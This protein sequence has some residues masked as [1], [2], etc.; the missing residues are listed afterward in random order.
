MIDITFVQSEWRYHVWAVPLSNVMSIL[1]G[2]SNGQAR[3]PWREKKKKKG[4]NRSLTM[5]EM[6]KYRLLAS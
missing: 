3:S 6:E 2:G 4:S 5:D 1:G